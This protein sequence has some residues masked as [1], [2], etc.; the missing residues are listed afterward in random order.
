MTKYYYSCTLV[1]VVATQFV[2]CLKYPYIFLLTVL[3][4]SN[5]ET[6]QF[7]EV[8]GGGSYPGC[9]VAGV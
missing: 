8:C 4:I 1:L 3:G 5:Q 9:K 7:K 6:T 2:H